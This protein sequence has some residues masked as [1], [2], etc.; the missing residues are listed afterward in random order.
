MPLIASA[1]FLASPALA[2]NPMR[3][4]QSEIRN[5]TTNEDTPNTKRGVAGTVTSINGT[6]LIVTSR[7]NIQYTVDAAHA[8]I[9]K[10]G[11]EPNMNPAIVGITDIK[12]GDAIMVRGTITNTEVSAEKIFD[13]RP[14][15]KSFSKTHS[16]SKH[17]PRASRHF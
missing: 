4:G 10:A 8:M 3:T 17:G 13:G 16:R 1:V 2:S 6:I 11:A 15:A 9:M 5:I 7:D 12:V 14:H